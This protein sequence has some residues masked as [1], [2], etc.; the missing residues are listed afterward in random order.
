MCV[1]CTGTVRLLCTV[2][3]LSPLWLKLVQ[4]W[5]VL[6]NS[7]VWGKW[8]GPLASRGGREGGSWANLS[9]QRYTILHYLAQ[10]ARAGRGVA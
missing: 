8:Y 7:K 5:P 1:L 2:Y 6:D 9:S 10:V 4:D 3:S